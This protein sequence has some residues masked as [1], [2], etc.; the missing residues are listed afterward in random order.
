[1]QEKQPNFYEVRAG[2]C[3][4]NH[5]VKRF[6]GAAKGKARAEEYAEKF[7]EALQAAMG[8]PSEDMK[9]QKP[10]FQQRPEEYDLASKVEVYYDQSASASPRY[11]FEVI[12]DD[13]PM[14][15]DHPYDY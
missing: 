4:M 15:T 14:P 8:L 12:G 5:V 3:D 6:T 1:M 11:G 2:T 9:V 13:D 10:N 7:N